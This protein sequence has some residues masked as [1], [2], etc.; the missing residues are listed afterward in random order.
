MAIKDWHP[1]QLGVFL[2]AA[3]LVSWAGLA[4]MTSTDPFVFYVGVLLLLGAFVSGFI[5]A[6][7]WF[8]RRRKPESD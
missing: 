3:F 7:H 2:V 1:G 5:V 4:A 6:W 8:G